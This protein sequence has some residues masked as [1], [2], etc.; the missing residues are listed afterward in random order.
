MDIV[1]RRATPAAGIQWPRK[2]S[3]ATANVHFSRLRANPIG[4]ED[5]KCSSKEHHYPELFLGFAVHAVII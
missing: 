4:A 5:G 1:P 3:S 2:S